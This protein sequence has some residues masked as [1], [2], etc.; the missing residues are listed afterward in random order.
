[1]LTHT[2][3]DS[4]PWMLS[5]H[6]QI[7]Y[8]FREFIK[9][10]LGSVPYLRYPVPN[11]TPLLGALIPSSK[12]TQPQVFSCRVRPQDLAAYLHSVQ[13]LGSVVVVAKVYF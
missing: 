9:N 13:P 4:P 2:S 5:R 8:C 7:C 12:W 3:K 1:M 6:F 10:H 11:R